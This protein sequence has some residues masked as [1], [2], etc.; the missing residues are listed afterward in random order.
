MYIVLKYWCRL[1]SLDICRGC[2][3]SNRFNSG[4]IAQIKTCPSAMHLHKSCKQII[5]QTNCPFWLSILFKWRKMYRS[6]ISPRLGSHMYSYLYEPGLQSVFNIDHTILLRTFSASQYN[7]SDVICFW[8]SLT[9][10][11]GNAEKKVRSSSL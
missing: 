11:R 5:I 7:D 1:E 2:C 9:H 6:G 8:F 10:Q 4:F 3:N